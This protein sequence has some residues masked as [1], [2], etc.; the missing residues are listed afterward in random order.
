MVYPQGATLGAR[1]RRTVAQILGGLPRPIKVDARESRNRSDVD[2]LD[3][4][5]K[6]LPVRVK[7]ECDLVIA[8]GRI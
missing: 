4:R 2:G 8:N 6:C 7:M 3:R 1:C 5:G